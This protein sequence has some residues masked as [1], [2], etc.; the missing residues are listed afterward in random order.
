MIISRKYIKWKVLFAV[1][2]VAVSGVL[3]IGS[4]ER[5]TTLTV[6]RSD[7]KAYLKFEIK[8]GLQRTYVDE[9]DLKP[10]SQL[11]FSNTS[12]DLEEP[13]NTSIQATLYI[14]KP[15]VASILNDTSKRVIEVLSVLNENEVKSREQV[16]SLWKKKNATQGRILV[17]LLSKSVTWLP[18]H[19]ILNLR[20]P[21][22]K[23]MFIL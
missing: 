16:K 3:L 7:E 1:S 19:K 12:L 9:T 21:N 14:P 22:L 17:C 15:Q 5:R 11:L 4:S 10:T 8:N 18:T 2:F 13:H 20:M 23:I 6:Q